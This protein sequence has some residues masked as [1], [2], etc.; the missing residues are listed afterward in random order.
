MIIVIHVE[1]V[2]VAVDSS[3]EVAGVHYL[4][5]EVEDKHGAEQAATTKVAS[6]RT[7]R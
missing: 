4:V 6:R 2:A 5:G 3:A 7:V 1:V